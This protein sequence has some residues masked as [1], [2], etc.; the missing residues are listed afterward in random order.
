MKA[1]LLFLFFFFFAI[2][3]F[4]IDTTFA[5]CSYNGSNIVGSI[6][7]CLDKTYLVQPG[8]AL[9]E[10][11]MKQKVIFWTYSLITAFSLFTIGAV[12]Y[13]GFLMTLSLWDDEKVSKG[14]DVIKWALLWF[15][16]AILAWVIVRFII[17]LLYDIGG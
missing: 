4:S 9:L 15:I 8:D 17:E 16:G 1:K 6:S 3:F 13:G 7:S 2:V 14:K 5:G 10:S 12:V 11:G